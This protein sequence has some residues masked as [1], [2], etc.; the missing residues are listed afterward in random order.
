MTI[1]GEK[2]FVKDQP[3]THFSMLPTPTPVCPQSF[4]G[5]GHEKFLTPFF[6][7]RVPISPP[8]NSPSTENQASRSKTPPTQLQQAGKQ[9]LGTGEGPLLDSSHRPRAAKRGLSLVPRG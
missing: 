9:P 3:K 2:F 6:H 1:S 4:I 5:I 7:P 8:L